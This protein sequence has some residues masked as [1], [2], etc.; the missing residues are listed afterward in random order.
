RA[1]A[2]REIRDPRGAARARRRLRRRPAGGAASAPGLPRDRGRSLAGL[3]RGGARARPR[4]GLDVDYVRGV[5]EALPADDGMFDAV[6][7]C[8]VLEHV[9]DLNATIREAARVL[10]PG[11]LYL[12]DTINRTMRSKLLVIKVFQEWRLTAFMPPNL[13]DHAVFIKPAELGALLRSFGLEPGPIVGIGPGV[14]PRRGTRLRPARRRGRLT[15][16]ELGRALQMREQS[17]TSAFYAGAATK[18]AVTVGHT[19]PHQFAAVAAT[20]AAAN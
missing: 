1:R 3:A 2:A 18:P 7:C 4:S 6:V 20:A 5:A 11:G 8:D 17:D 14:A 15:Y 9:S 13:H 12:Y 19:A 16:G 10:R